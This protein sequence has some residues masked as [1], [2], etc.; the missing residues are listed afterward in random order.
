M[1]YWPGG[2][3]WNLRPFLQH[4][5]L[6]GDLDFVKKRVLPL[7]REMAEFYEDYLVPGEDGRYHQVGIS[8]ENFP[9]PG[10]LLCNDA[11]MD[12]AVAREVFGALIQ[13]GRQFKLD[14]ADIAKWQAY[15]DKLPAYR[16]NEDGALAEWIDPRY[17][18]IYEHR[19]S[20][21]LYPIWP[22]TELLQPGT[23][24][25]L[26]KAAQVALDRRFMTDTDAAHGLMHVALIAARLHDVE[27]VRIN[28]DRFSRRGYVYTG[29]VTSHGPKKQVYNLDS[30]LSLPCLLIEMLVYTDPG[31]IELMPAWPK[32]FPD[33]HITGI[34]VQNGHK[35]DITWAAGKL[36][37]ATLHPARSD[38]CEIR[39]GDKVKSV[40]LKAGKPF[41]FTP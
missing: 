25:A 16:I 3:G 9:T 23:D 4:A 38:T 14:G 13:M 24:S 5:Q 34:R 1:M 33:G 26:L 29:L 40:S 28:I 11:T 20:S 10:T 39:Y 35:L 2:A 41:Q 36:V 31:H 27:K 37:S 32:N 18:D 30:I 12:V 7:Y 6:T 8:P 21:H 17:K 22:G 15:L 19:H